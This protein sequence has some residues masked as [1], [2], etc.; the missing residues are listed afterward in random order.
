MYAIKEREFKESIVDSFYT[1]PQFKES[2]PVIVT[3]LAGPRFDE[4]AILASRKLKAIEINSYEIDEETFALQTLQLNNLL[5]PEVA[6]I[7][8][9][10]LQDVNKCFVSNFMDIDLMGTILTQGNTIRQL[11]EQQS[12][13]EGTKAFIG[14]F[15]IRR[16][17]L[18]STVR[19]IENLINIVLNSRVYA[20]RDDLIKHSSGRLQYKHKLKTYVNNR[21]DSF[22]LYHYSDKEGAMVTFRI[23]YT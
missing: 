23:V 22:L 8:T 2:E 21:V 19:F 15:S 17:G 11:L 12:Y 10:H 9:L 16:V 18:A 14:T 7:S 13:L 1:C 6:A 4:L 20:D 3:T 5:M